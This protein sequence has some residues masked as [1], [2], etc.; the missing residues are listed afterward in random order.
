[1]DKNS[2]HYG[3][4]IL[5]KSSQPPKMYILFLTYI[6]KYYLQVKSTWGGKKSLG[7]SY[8]WYLLFD[9]DCKRERK[10]QESSAQLRYEED[11]AA[12]GK[13]EDCV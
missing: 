8:C 7:I 2:C 6:I 4:Y 3:L 9:T 11:T 10:V 13:G 1:M 12:E 5:T